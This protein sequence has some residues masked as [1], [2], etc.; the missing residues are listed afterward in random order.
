LESECP[1]SYGNI[2][3]FSIF[4]LRASSPYAIFI[5]GK[6]T[7]PRTKSATLRRP[8]TGNNSSKDHDHGSHEEKEE[9]EESGEEASVIRLSSEFESGW[10]KIRP[11]SF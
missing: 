11:L 4:L 10:M 8:P 2:R 7:G 9:D 1:L 6:G 5:H 3:V